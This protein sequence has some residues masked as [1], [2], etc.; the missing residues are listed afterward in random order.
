MPD[1][2]FCAFILTHGRPDRVHTYRTLQK[3][4]YTGRV[5]FVVD[6]EDRTLPE[7]QRRFGAS[8]VLV[9]SKAEMAKTFDE[10]DNTGDRRAIVYA[11]NACW[12]FARQLGVRSFVQLDD[13]YGSF[14]HRFDEDHRFGYWKCRNLD[15]LFAL[16]VEYLTATPF[17][18]IA[19]AQG[20]DMLGGGGSLQQST[21]RTKRKAM[22]TFVCL[23]SRPFEF[24]GRVNEDVNTYTATQRRGGPFLTLLALQVN[25]KPTQSNAGGMTDL[26]RDSGTYLKSFY[27]VV[28]AP[29]CVVV[30]PLKDR[31][32]GARIHHRVRWEC[33]APMI[34]PERFRKASA[35][36]NT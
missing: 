13:D 28:Y 36:P 26:Y 29:S 6:D 1:D 4:G 30:A 2:S 11:R 32:S 20:G 23:T 10:G 7:Y 25:Q 21:I 31:D 8:R 33:A 3:H 5:Y 14:G 27:S 12:H 17:L 15:R 16:V 18:S 35:M 24:V 19:F 34:V 9:F 22:N